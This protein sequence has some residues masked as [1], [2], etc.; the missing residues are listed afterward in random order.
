MYQVTHEMTRARVL[1][2]RVL[3]AKSTHARIVHIHDV[4]K[5]TDLDVNSEKSVW[6]TS[7][8][9]C[10]N[11]PMFQ[12]SHHIMYQE[13][14]QQAV[15]FCLS[16]LKKMSTNKYMNRWCQRITM[17]SK[18]R[19]RTK[20][21]RSSKTKKDKCVLSPKDEMVYVQIH[22]TEELGTK[23]NSPEGKVTRNLSVE[24]EISTASFKLQINRKNT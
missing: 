19:R 11:E 22:E 10:T 20:S 2:R 12:S 7:S 17:S 1:N 16:N 24:F 6:G 3:S 15:S 13:Q 9:D 23:L 4:I 18:G 5:L 14:P 21:F 8:M